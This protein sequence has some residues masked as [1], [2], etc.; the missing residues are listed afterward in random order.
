MLTGNDFII[1]SS[2][3]T[4]LLYKALHM[5]NDRASYKELA[6]LGILTLVKDI[7]RFLYKEEE[8]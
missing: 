3:E 4:E 1:L 7:E 8:E 5:K 6:D 2:S